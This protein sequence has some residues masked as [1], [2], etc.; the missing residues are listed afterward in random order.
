MRA[1]QEWGFIDGR[2]SVST[3]LRSARRLCEDMET[4][5]VEGFGLGYLLIHR[6]GGR[7]WK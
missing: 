4:G 3:L 1:R 7:E 6:V 5:D 2:N